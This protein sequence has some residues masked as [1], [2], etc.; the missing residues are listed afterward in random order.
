[1]SIARL[2]KEWGLNDN[3]KNLD[4]LCFWIFTNKWSEMFKILVVVMVVV[5]VVVMVCGV[6][7][8]DFSALKS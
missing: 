2:Q 8:Q 7:D 4:Y 3:H 6:H 1:M 5:V